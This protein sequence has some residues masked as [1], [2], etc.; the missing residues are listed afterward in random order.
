MSESK[1]LLDTVRSDKEEQYNLLDKGMIRKLTMWHVKALCHECRSKKR[2]VSDF[3]KALE[4]EFKYINDFESESDLSQELQMLN[5]AKRFA[6]NS[7][8]QSEEEVRVLTL[9]DVE[10]IIGKNI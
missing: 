9:E 6:E 4:K 1:K 7:D 8:K 5:M 3:V 2:G 10:M